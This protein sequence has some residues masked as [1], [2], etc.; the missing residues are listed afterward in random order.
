MHA[1][2][3]FCERFFAISLTFIHLG[4]ICNDAGNREGRRVK[5]E[6]ICNHKKAV[7]SFRRFG[8][9]FF[10]VLAEAIMSPSSL[11]PVAQA[12]DHSMNTLLNTAIV[13]LWHQSLRKSMG[14]TFLLQNRDSRPGPD[15]FYHLLENHT[16]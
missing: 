14:N 13:P 11:D 4:S 5:N 15:M 9:I 3:I 8:R 12:S 1:A 16:S 7:Y 6:R 2:D 10:G